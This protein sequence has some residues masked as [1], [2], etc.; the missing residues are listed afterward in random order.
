MGAPVSGTIVESKNFPEGLS[1]LVVD[2]DLL[3]LKVV[4]KMLKTCKYKGASGFGSIGSR[5][6]MTHAT[7]GLSTISCSNLRRTLYEICS[8]V[9]RGQTAP[10]QNE[11]AS[12]H[13]TPFVLY[14]GTPIRPLDEGLA[15]V[16]TAKLTFRHL[17]RKHDRERIHDD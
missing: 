11:R 6:L 15:S 9:F 7:H 10:K 1:V 13:A 8:G 14:E 3:C 12:R 17:V 5:G 4:E 16:R 2:D